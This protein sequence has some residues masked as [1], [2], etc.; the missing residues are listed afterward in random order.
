[1]DTQQKGAVV[2]YHKR[3]E[4]SYSSM[5][6]IIDSGIDYAVAA[7][8][9]DLGEP[10]SKFIDMGQL[11]HMIILGGEDTFAVSDFPDFRT[12]AAREWRDEQLEAG[13]NIITQQMFDDASDIIAHVEA[14]PFSKQFLFGTGV[15]HEQEV[16]AATAEGV[17]L[18]GKADAIKLA[19]SAAI[20]TDIKTTAQFD[21][22]FKTAQSKHYDL[23]A[24]NY[25]LMTASSLKVDPQLINFMF[26]VVETVAP[27]RVQYMHASL[28]FVEAGERKLRNCIDEIVKFGDKTPNFLIEDIR[29]LG[30]WSI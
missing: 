4:W 28:E 5:K 24:A 13:K 26:C 1:M 12:K 8:N 27:Y 18:R 15:T 11:V 7:K 10:Q 22:F 17:K 19:N 16:F 6:K 21:K 25:T 14:H 9:G 30:D 29:E 2:D 20:I 23:Q 3:P